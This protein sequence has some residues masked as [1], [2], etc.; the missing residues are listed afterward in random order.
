[1]LNLNVNLNQACSNYS[2]KGCVAAGFLFN[3][4]AAHQTC[5]I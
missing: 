3:Q 5:L 1:M 2:T 4:A